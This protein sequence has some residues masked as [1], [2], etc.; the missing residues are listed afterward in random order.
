[1][2]QAAKDKERRRQLY[3][4]AIVAIIALLGINIY[5]FMSNQNKEKVIVQQEEQL[6]LADSLRSQ[7]E[8]EYQ[9]A[10]QELDAKAAENEELRDI[11]DQQKEQL[12]ILKNK[13]KRNIER[14]VTTK[15]L[16]KEAEAQ[17][18][19]LKVKT[20]GYIVTI[21]S[22]TSANAD[23]VQY[24]EV[25]KEEKA[26]LEET[27]ETTIVTKDEEIKAKEK[28][29]KQVE[30]EKEKLAEKVTRGSAL[31]VRNISTK[32]LRIRRNGKEKE[33]SRASRV[34]KFNIC[35]DVIKNE[36]TDAGRNKFILRI[37]NPKGETI[38]V[39]QRGSGTFSN[40]E[41]NGTQS[42]FTISK[43]F[44]YNNDA[45][46]ICIDWIQ[47]EKLEDKGDYVFEIYNRG[48]LAGKSVVKLK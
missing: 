16:L 10:M 12:T 8:E 42:R 28:E 1:M 21:D 25:L 4:I 24:S 18:A 40:Q 44:E 30:Q 29:K 45:P 7:L 14:G 26:D 48:Y 23:L 36:L 9:T 6:D 20:N 19:S 35:F 46:N 34:E 37:V 15:S 27:L 5:Q 17:I 38:A 13:I 39:E 47:E 22:L 32:A 11:V 3:A 2:S 43:S 31:V 41:V 33:T